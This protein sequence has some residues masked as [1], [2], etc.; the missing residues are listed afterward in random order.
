M[1][2]LRHDQRLRRGVA[3]REGIEP[4]RDHDSPSTV[5]KTAAATRHAALS[6]NL[7]HLNKAK[8]HVN[9]RWG[10]LLG[11]DDCILVDVKTS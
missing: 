9:A 4:T 3:E 2:K 7:D 10:F 6:L 5:L 8:S 11:N 1:R